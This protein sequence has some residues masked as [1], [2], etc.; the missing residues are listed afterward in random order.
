MASAKQILQDFLEGYGLGSLADWAWNLYVSSG[1]DNITSFVQGQLTVEL[2]KTE[3]FKARFPAY[4]ALRQQG[5]GISVDQYRQYEQDAINLAKQYGAPA[6]MFE[7]RDYLARIMTAGVSTRELEQ[8]FALNREAAVNVPP[9]VRQALTQM[10]GV[11][12]VDGAL[13]AYYF[14]P[15]GSLPHLQQQFQAAQIAGAG[16]QQAF[17]VDRSQAERLAQQGITWEQ[18]Q[19]GF[20]DAAAA[21]GLTY[22]QGDTVTEAQTIGGAFGDQAAG[23]EVTRVK[24]ARVGAFQA[25]GGAV[26][27]AKGVTGL[28]STSR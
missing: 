9:E 4:D 8:R 27:S 22:G 21:R 3:A 5:Q 24:R 2:P 1:T 26:D 14:D 12:N 20:R 23:A 13:T 15:E 28:G 6:S 11:S 19:S 10:Y 17:Q 18:A 7:D 16:L 25:G